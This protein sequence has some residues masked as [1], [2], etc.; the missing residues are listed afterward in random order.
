MVKYFELINYAWNEKIYV[1]NFVF[2]YDCVLQ[3]Q[4]TLWAT[5]KKNDQTM[6]KADKKPRS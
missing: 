6:A 3:T 1:D 5:N 4:S 2:N